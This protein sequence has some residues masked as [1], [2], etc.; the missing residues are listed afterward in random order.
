VLISSGRWQSIGHYPL[1]SPSTAR[2]EAKKLL[3]EK[4][5][6]NALRHVRDGNTK[7]PLHYIYRDTEG[8]GLS[9]CF[10]KREMWITETNGRVSE[11][12]ADGFDIPSHPIKRDEHVFAYLRLAGEPSAN[13]LP[14][15][16]GG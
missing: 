10:I 3:A 12:R 6:G 11:L 9:T 15:A 14:L 7:V 2:T 1:G 16:S 13:H 5:L 8:Y 4:M